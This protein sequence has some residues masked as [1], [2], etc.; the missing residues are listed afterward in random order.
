MF[1]HNP[2]FENTSVYLRIKPVRDNKL[3]KY[4]AKAYPTQ[5]YGLSHG[6][7]LEFLA[8]YME[9][10]G[11]YQVLNVTNFQFVDQSRDTGNWPASRTALTAKLHLPENADQLNDFL[12]RQYILLDIAQS[13]LRRQPSLIV[14]AFTPNESVSP[15]VGDLG[16][17][18]APNANIVPP[19][20][21][22][23][24]TQ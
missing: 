5:G 18:K 12:A 21:A 8:R 4:L 16:V 17:V 24:I 11:I 22:V 9:V 10:A 13:K 1:R 19:E 6:K 14:R 2:S 20:G 15:F 23:I 3:L 7:G